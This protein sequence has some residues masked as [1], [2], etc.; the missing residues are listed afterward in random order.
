ML[1]TY[2]LLVVIFSLA[3]HANN[4]DSKIVCDNAKAGQRRL[5]SYYTIW[6]RRKYDLNYF[7]KIEYKKSKIVLNLW[8][9]FTCGL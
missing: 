1:A 8:N 7:H 6:H 9:T 4:A 5:E 2:Y 3:Q